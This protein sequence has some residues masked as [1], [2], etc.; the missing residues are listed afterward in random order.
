[1]HDMLRTLPPEKKSNWKQYLPEL[2]MAY[3][4]RTHTSTGYSP[5]YLMFGRDARMPLDILGWR[6]LEDS[7]VDNLDD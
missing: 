7:G 4:S 1:M 2:V 3:N 6:D 5:F